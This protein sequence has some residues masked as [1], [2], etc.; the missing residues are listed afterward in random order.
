MGELSADK[1]AYCDGMDSFCG[2][3]L[4]A[5]RILAIG[6]LVSVTGIVSLLLFGNRAKSKIILPFAAIWSF[7]AICAIAASSV[8]WLGSMEIF[9]DI[10]VKYFDYFGGSNGMVLKAYATSTCGVYKDSCWTISYGIPMLIG[11]GIV[12][13]VGIPL[14]GV[15]AS[16]E[17]LNR[18]ECAEAQ[19]PLLQ[20]K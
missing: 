7:V 4:Q 19:L 5:A 8:L 17:K 16:K 11:T 18:I 3:D 2:A 14:Y 20:K 15:A 1:T 9:G 13:F 12:L 10:P 6:A